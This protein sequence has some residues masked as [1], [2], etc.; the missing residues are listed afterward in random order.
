[1]DLYEFN[2]LQKQLDCPIISILFHESLSPSAADILHT[3]NIGTYDI[4]R[5]QTIALND[6]NDISAGLFPEMFPYGCRH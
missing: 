6:R 2:I 3:S 4:Q 5:T 1:M